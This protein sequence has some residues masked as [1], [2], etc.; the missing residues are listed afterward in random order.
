MLMR[1]NVLP[2]PR[3]YNLVVD[4]SQWRDGWPRLP[5]CVNHHELRGTL[6]DSFV[7]LI[8]A[9]EVRRLKIGFSNGVEHR[10]KQI[11]GASPV[12][13]YLLCSIRGTEADEFAL[14]ERFSDLHCIGE[15]FEWDEAILAH[16]ESV[17]GEMLETVA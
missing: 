10:F 4:S 8:G 2:S 1:G 14:H 17:V 16:F 9:P 6:R 7:Y 12:E 13:I 5:A 11:A 3:T 15:W